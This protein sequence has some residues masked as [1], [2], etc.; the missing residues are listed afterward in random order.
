MYYEPNEWDDADDDLARALRE[1]IPRA[2][3]TFNGILDEVAYNAIDN[4]ISPAECKEWVPK[5]LK[6]RV[7]IKRAQVLQQ[8]RER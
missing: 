7:E 8:D 3:F 6:N 2:A 5:E 1:S 4:D